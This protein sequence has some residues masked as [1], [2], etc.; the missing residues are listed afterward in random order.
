MSA[1]ATQS[2]LFARP[3][4]EFWVSGTPVPQGD[5]VPFRFWPKEVRG[6]L[7]DMIVGELAEE[8]IA[9][10]PRSSRQR[11]VV[12]ERIMKRVADGQQ[13][14]LHHAHARELESWRMAV[15]A[16]ARKAWNGAPP[17]SCGLELDLDFFL[18]RPTT[19]RRVLHTVRPDRDKLLRAVADA[20]AGIIYVDDSQAIG[21]QTRKHY[22]SNVG[23]GV[24]IRVNEVCDG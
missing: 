21:G 1:A 14:R 15:A 8:R 19:V 20:L 22:A 16:A 7:V 6:D 24:R 3:A 5:L 18:P 10:L 23:P 12:A 13:V 2:A 9:V 11:E 17:I 4:V